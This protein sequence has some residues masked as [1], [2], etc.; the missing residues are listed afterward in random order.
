MPCE[1]VRVCGMCSNDVYL[2]SDLGH[3]PSWQDLKVRL[4]STATEAV[5]IQTI[6]C[7]LPKQ[8]VVLDCGILDPGL[9]RDVSHS[10]LWEKYYTIITREEFYLLILTHKKK[11]GFSN[12]LKRN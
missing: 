8:N 7:M 2:F 3:V 6:I 12:R 11:A 1:G 5:V 10:T 9:L 4:Q